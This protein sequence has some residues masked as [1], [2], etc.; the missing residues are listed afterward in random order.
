MFKTSTMDMLLYLI[1]SLTLLVKI[2]IS[3]TASNHNLITSDFI[4]GQIIQFMGPAMFSS[5]LFLS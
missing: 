3:F 1:L 5:L 4:A 2:L